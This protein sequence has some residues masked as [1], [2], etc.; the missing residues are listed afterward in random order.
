MEYGEQSVKALLIWKRPELSATNLDFY[1]L[2][3][4]KVQFYNIILSIECDLAII[5]VYSEYI[6]QNHLQF[7]EVT[8]VHQ[9]ALHT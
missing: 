3:S 8:T 2:V 4:Y 5:S 1:I 9:M 7:I 6:I